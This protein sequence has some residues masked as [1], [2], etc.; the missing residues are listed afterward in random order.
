[1]DE[2][3]HAAILDTQFYADVQGALGLVL[4]HRPSGASEQESEQR[5]KRLTAMK[6]IYC[7]FFSTDPLGYAPCQPSGPQL[8]RR[9]RNPSSIFVKTLTGKT[10]TLEVESSDTIYN[11]KSKIQDKEGIPPEYQMLIFAGK[12]VEDAKT[13]QDYGIGHK[14]TLHIVLTIR[15]C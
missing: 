1:M 3:W 9:L 7:A 15:G 5:E 8:A 2:L 13:L 14:S 11:V 4:H 6:A 10:I 12:L